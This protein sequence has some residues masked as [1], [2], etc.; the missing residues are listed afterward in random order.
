M[1]RQSVNTR[2]SLSHRLPSGD[3]E[4]CPVVATEF[5]LFRSSR[6]VGRGL[7]LTQYRL[8]LASKE[9]YLV[10]YG[11]RGNCADEL[12]QTAHL[13]ATRYAAA[14]S[15]ICRVCLRYLF[16][17]DMNLNRYYYI[18]YIYILA[19]S[20]IAKK[21]T[22]SLLKFCTITGSREARC[23]AGA[24]SSRSLTLCT[25]NFISMSL[26]TAP[27]A[28]KCFIWSV[29]YILKQFPGCNAAFDKKW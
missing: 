18:C 15:N 14:T 16:Y 3:E 2:S 10:A 21:Y 17:D 23:M 6:P 22:V 11:E 19:I 1:E 5:K 4:N 9:L 28:F 29:W 13:H 25:P 12:Q 8:R 27:N 24:N 26:P 20:K 7:E